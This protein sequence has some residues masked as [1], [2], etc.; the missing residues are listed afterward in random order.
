MIFFATE[1]CFY[2]K[3]EHMF[4]LTPEMY[5]LCRYIVAT[6]M[7]KLLMLLRFSDF[8]HSTDVIVLIGLFD[9]NTLIIR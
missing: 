5:F 1:T 7:Q 8:F 6:K 9:L 3:F 2:Y 4:C